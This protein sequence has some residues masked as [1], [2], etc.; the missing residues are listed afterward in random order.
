[1]TILRIFLYLICTFSIGW[2]VI[3]FGGPVIIKKVISGYTNGALVASDITLSPTLK[4]NIGR[5]DFT[6][7][8]NRPEKLVEGSS[9]AAEISWSL[10]GQK[11]FL[12]LSFGPTFLR[13]YASADNMHIYTPNVHEIDWK[14]IFFDINIKLNIF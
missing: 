12:D 5:L 4:I 6:F 2:S 10:F 7:T 8:N 14:N 9:R 13:D 11:P 3:V 1:M